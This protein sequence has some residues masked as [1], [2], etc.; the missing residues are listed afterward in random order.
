M[1]KPLQ[2][3]RHKS[4]VL[5]IATEGTPASAAAIAKLSLYA[6]ER[7]A[8]GRPGIPGSYKH[9]ESAAI[10]QIAADTGI[11]RG[12]LQQPNVVAH[13]ESLIQ[14]FGI[15]DPSHELRKEAVKKLRSIYRSTG[16]P[17]KRDKTPN[18]ARIEEDSELTRFILRSAECEAFLRAEISAGRYFRTK[19]VQ[20]QWLPNV[21]NYIESL[22]EKGEAVPINI[23]TGELYIEVIAEACGIPASKLR[24]RARLIK[25][26]KDAVEE[27]GTTAVLATTDETARLAEV[28][29]HAIANKI[30]IPRSLRR[31]AIAYRVL[32][33]KLQI[34]ESRLKTNVEMQHLL[35]SWHEACGL[36]TPIDETNA[37]SSFILSTDA[38]EKIGINGASPESSGKKAFIT[39]PKDRP[40]S[41]AVRKKTKAPLEHRLQAYLRSLRESGKTLPEASRTSPIRNGKWSDTQRTLIDKLDLRA[42]ASGCGHKRL[43]DL[44]ENPVCMCLIE[45]I[46]ELGVGPHLFRAP[47]LEDLVQHSYDRRYNEV[48]QGATPSSASDQASNTRT[49]LQSL[50][51][52]SHLP[53]N[54][55]LKDLFGTDDVFGRAQRVL[56]NSALTPKTSKKYNVELNRVRSYALD[57]L[58]ASQIPMQF[59]SA[60]NE[61]MIRRGV[62]V[63]DLCKNVSVKRAT[64][65]SWLR[66][67]EPKDVSHESV[68]EIEGFL[69]VEQG[70]L[71]RRINQKQSRIASDDILTPELRED[72]NNAGIPTSFLP[73]DW[74]HRTPAQKQAIVDWISERILASSPYSRYLKAIGKDYISHDPLPSMMQH[75]F[76]AIRE[77]KTA[78]IPDVTLGIQRAKPDA[79]KGVQSMFD[80][81]WRE[82]SANLMLKALQR[83]VT[84]MKG[85]TSE[86]GLGTDWINDAGLGFLANAQCLHTII[87]AMA[88]RRFKLLA[89]ANAFEDMELKPPASKAVYTM[90]DARLIGSIAGFFD[91]VTGYFFAC[92]PRVTP[93][94]GL[95][96]EEWVQQ[97]RSDWATVARKGCKE[98]RQL[99][100]QI[101]ARARV[102]RDPWEPIAPLVER[103]DPLTPVFNALDRMGRDRPDP[104]SGPMAVA[105][106][107][108][109]H[110]V[111]SLLMH[112]RVRLLNLSTL[113]WKLDNTGHLR[114]LKGTW[115]L[116]IPQEE[117]KN[118]GSPA[119]PEDGG[120]LEIE[121]DPDDKELNDALDR[122]LVGKGCSRSV[123]L[124]GTESDSL[125]AG[126]QGEKLHS[127]TIR[128]IV[129]KFS[130]RYV[131]ECPWREGGVPGV[132][133]FGPHAFRH[134]VATHVMR[135]TGNFEAAALSIN[136]AVN[137][138][139]KTY[140]KFESRD[141]SRFVSGLIKRSVQRKDMS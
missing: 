130:V 55:L 39:V 30:P 76:D 38:Q 139:K 40:P 34:R 122:Y 11:T 90:N 13:L 45:A 75:D 110:L 113:T 107:D 86:K 116:S 23:K 69:A 57:L 120:P 6:A 106:H 74:K 95:V 70:L 3:I 71:S 124:S 68:R 58:E 41:V 21:T 125:F 131:A 42:I 12:M 117:L 83:L 36:S 32:A 56:L 126:R 60:L 89:D 123:I 105:Q 121:L 140:A 50:I 98:L 112:S 134:L 49:A 65:E 67:V 94:P 44:L 108:R 8:A 22:R 28:V 137:T 79:P 47:R 129:K 93:I 52:E 43:Q 100:D 135:Q 109:D 136:D 46:D 66:G 73:D 25:A 59:G 24:E 1:T 102:I 92:S 87:T 17:V 115:I 35:R 77:F 27:L 62:S 97:A 132:L 78:E 4:N 16:V 14:Q 138:A 101:A 10:E 15:E 84:A 5:P 31:P 104:S 118:E 133:P 114:R 19:N 26:L 127:G 103:D 63:S 111:I 128:R 33:A 2:Q 119:L 91:D 141:G 80:G 81:H 18:L 51:R 64:V 88:R 20:D 61:L 7:V 85:I 9:P 53:L 54:M 48:A 72:F 99:G 29:N 37:E 96:S 82:T